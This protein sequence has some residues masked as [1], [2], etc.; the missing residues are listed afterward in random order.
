ML[1][2]KARACSSTAAG[3]RGQEHTPGRGRARSGQDAHEQTTSVPHA[4]AHPDP[5]GLSQ[6]M[7]THFVENPVKILAAHHCFKPLQQ[8]KLAIMLSL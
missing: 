3:A 2:D 1:Q 6:A 7:K 4:N 8:L 5:Q